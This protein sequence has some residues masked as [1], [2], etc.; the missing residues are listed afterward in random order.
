MWHSTM[1][2]NERIW[3]NQPLKKVILSKDNVDLKGSFLFCQDAIENLKKIY[4][5]L[6]KKKRK[7][8]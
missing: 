1:T 5:L 8:K 2:R 3:V 6:K 4:I 7:S